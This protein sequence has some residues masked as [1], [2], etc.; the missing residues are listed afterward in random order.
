MLG[1]PRLRFGELLLVLLNYPHKLRSRLANRNWFPSHVCHAVAVDLC[2]LIYRTRGGCV[3]PEGP[4]L[5]GLPTRVQEGCRLHGV[6]TQQLLAP[7]EARPH[8]ARR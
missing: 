5:L 6:P 3:S 1:M 4:L 7:R 2:S 8:P